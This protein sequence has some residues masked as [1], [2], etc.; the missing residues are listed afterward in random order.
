[1]S[2]PETKPAAPKTPSAVETL[3]RIQE[4]ARSLERRFTESIDPFFI[5]PGAVAHRA[6]ILA[7][8]CGNLFDRLAGQVLAL[9]RLV[10]NTRKQMDTHRQAFVEV[11]TRLEACEKTLGLKKDEEPV[12][13]SPAAETAPAEVEAVAAPLPTMNG[14]Q[15]TP[16]QQQV[17]A[18]AQGQKGAAQ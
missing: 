9:G 8:V 16:E 4:L 1:M 5:T 3:T 6:K 11:A 12:E 7:Q 2:I 17:L 13:A 15:L 10:E 18:F 14:Q